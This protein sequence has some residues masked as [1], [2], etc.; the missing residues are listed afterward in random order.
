MGDTYVLILGFGLVYMGY[1]VFLGWDKDP[2]P[3]LLAT[4][5][6]VLLVLGTQIALIILM[7]QADPK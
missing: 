3:G 6:R 5:G 2:R 1:A 7:N 4:L